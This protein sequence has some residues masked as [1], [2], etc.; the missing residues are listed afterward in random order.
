MKEQD[1]I[2]CF[3]YSVSIPLKMSRI[4]SVSIDGI[5]TIATLCVCEWNQLVQRFLLH[6]LIRDNFF[7][8]FQVWETLG[9][10][11]KLKTELNLEGR[12]NIKTAH[13]NVWILHRVFWLSLIMIFSRTNINNDSDDLPPTFNHSFLV[14]WSI[15][16]LPSIHDEFKAPSKIP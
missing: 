16:Q 4:N 12:L 9:R 6:Q 1:K 11:E 14:S 7:F 5:R 2:G 10:K 15:Y 3:P 8:H 13:F